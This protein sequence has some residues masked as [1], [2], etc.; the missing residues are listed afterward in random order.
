M[1]FVEYIKEESKK[2]SKDFVKATLIKRFH[3]DKK[4]TESELKNLAEK[5]GMSFSQINEMVYTILT[6]M[7]FRTRNKRAI[8]VDKKELEMGIEEEMEHTDSKEIAKIIALDHLYAVKN[9]YTLLKYVE[10][11]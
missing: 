11:K 1:K 9:Y 7:L 3:E 10:P 5:N 6:D 4:V 2:D 8:E